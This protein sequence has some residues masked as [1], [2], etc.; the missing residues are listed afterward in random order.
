MA[1]AFCTCTIPRVHFHSHAL[2]IMPYG[3]D[4]E[5][6]FSL[7]A[8]TITLWFSQTH[9][10]LIHA[11]HRFCFAHIVSFI[12]KAKLTERGAQSERSSTHCSFPKCLQIMQL[13]HLMPV[14]R[15]SICVYLIGCRNPV[16][17]PLP[18]APQGA[19]QQEAG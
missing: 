11:T 19:H 3:Q 7:K 16:F 2:L 15:N 6:R 17:E 1:S 4:R 12:S 14:T 9:V 5:R 10:F 8:R 18:A 13:A